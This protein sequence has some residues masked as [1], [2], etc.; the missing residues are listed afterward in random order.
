MGALEGLTP[1][2]RLLL[3]EAAIGRV[4]VRY[5]PG[6]ADAAAGEPASSDRHTRNIRALAPQDLHRP[7]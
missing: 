4:L 6:R 7:G 3:D 5:E 2:L 1:E